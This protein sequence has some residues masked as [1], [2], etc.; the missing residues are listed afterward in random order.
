VFLYSGLA[1]NDTTIKD[2]HSSGISAS[3][4]GETSNDNAVSSALPYSF[5]L[6]SFADS[7]LLSRSFKFPIVVSAI[8]FSA[9][10]VR[11]A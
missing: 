10:S 5:G 3:I 6:T 7:P 9:S 8:F 2:L 4:P 1:N 11:K